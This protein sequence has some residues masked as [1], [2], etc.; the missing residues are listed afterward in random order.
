MKPYYDDGMVQIYHADALE[1]LPQLSSVDL[2][3]TDP[4]YP[5]EYLLLYGVLAVQSARLLP[6]GG[7][8]F[9]YAGHM[10][11]PEVMQE[12][13]Q[14]QD[15]Q[16]FWMLSC[17]HQGS[18]AM[19]WSHGIGAHWKPILWYRKPPMTPLA[20]PVSDEVCSTRQKESHPWQQ[21]W[22]LGIHVERITTAGQTI[23]DPFC[24]SGTTLRAAKDLSRKA[25]GIEI[26][27]RYC[28]IAARRCSQEVLKFA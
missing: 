10:F 7:H 25:I 19:I 13:G 1:V 14:T 28:E 2:V 24:G 20:P 5:R 3:L 27:E 6:P 15:L 4:P 8:L 9:A 18:N 12:L 17:R 21:P 22:H 16:Y 26:E 11:L 23:L